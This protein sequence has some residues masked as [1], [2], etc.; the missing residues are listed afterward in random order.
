MKKKQT[1]MTKEQYEN[2]HWHEG[3]KYIRVWSTQH[4]KRNFKLITKKNKDEKRKIVGN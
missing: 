3:K 2:S 1:K 4:E